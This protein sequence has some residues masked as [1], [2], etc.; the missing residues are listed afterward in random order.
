MSAGCSLA[1]GCYFSYSGFQQA[2]QQKLAFVN[3]A[4]NAVM[5]VDNTTTLNFGA[6]RNSIRIV[7]K[8]QYTVGSVWVA[9]ML[10]MPFGVSDAL[11]RAPTVREGGAELL[12]R[13]VCLLRTNSARCGP[14]GGRLL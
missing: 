8:D 13:R 4:G 11:Q 14:R 9:D 3:D 10:H 2:S 6:N 5:K 12:M 7:S 1:A